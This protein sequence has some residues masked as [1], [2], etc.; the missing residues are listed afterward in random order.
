MTVAELI[1][2]LK[3]FPK[4]WRVG[5]TLQGNH[6]GEIHGFAFGVSELS[7]GQ[8]FDKFGPTVVITT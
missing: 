5:I 3:E 1:K 7:P 8:D 4:D 2:K 6:D